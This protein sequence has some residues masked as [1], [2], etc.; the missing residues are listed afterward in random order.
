METL[1]KVAVIVMAICIF[2]FL[3]GIAL[4]FCWNAVIPEV[5]GWKA[6]TVWQAILLIC[7]T[8]ILFRSASYS[9]K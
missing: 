7:V 6:I 3:G 8:S 5:I 4:M 2:G 9:S 1:I